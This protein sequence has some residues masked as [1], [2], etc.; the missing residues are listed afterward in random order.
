MKIRVLTRLDVRDQCLREI[1][2]LEYVR[3]ISD[4]RYEIRSEI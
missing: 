1:V 4:E 2:D 3:K